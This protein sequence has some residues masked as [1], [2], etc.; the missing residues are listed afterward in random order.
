M[1]LKRRQE[2]CHLNYEEHC[3]YQPDLA[4]SSRF[5]NIEFDVFITWQVPVDQNLSFTPV[6]FQHRLIVSINEKEVPR[7]Y[8]LVFTQLSNCTLAKQARQ[9]PKKISYQRPCYCVRTTLTRGQLLEF[10]S[11]MFDSISSH[12]YYADPQ[13]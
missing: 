3:R 10:C 9:V 7:K 13:P 4:S 6:I 5:V 12:Q 2:Q 1:A 8:C 11:V